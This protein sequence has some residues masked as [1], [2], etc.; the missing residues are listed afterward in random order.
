M[1]IITWRIKYAIIFSKTK[2]WEFDYQLSDV[3]LTATCNK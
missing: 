3:I 2:Y 1:K